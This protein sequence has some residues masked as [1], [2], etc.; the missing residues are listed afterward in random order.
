MRKILG[1]AAVGLIAAAVTLAVPATSNAQVVVAP[2]PVVTT[3]PVVAYRGY[4]P[5]YYSYYGPVVRPGVRVWGYPHYYYGHH[6]Y[7]HRW[8]R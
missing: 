3:V 5:Y 2:A 8:H 4:R 7:A 6:H 1:L